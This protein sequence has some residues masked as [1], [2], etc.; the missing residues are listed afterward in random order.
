[1]RLLLRCRPNQDLPSVVLP[2]LDR[3]GRSKEALLGRER[4][5]FCS[6]QRRR[7]RRRQRWQQQQKPITKAGRARLY[8][9]HKLANRHPN[10]SPPDPASSG[11]A[12]P[13][14][15]VLLTRVLFTLLPKPTEIRTATRPARSAPS[16]PGEAKRTA[17]YMCVFGGL[18]GREG[19]RDGGTEEGRME[20]LR[21]RSRARRAAET[22]STSEFRL[23]VFC[24]PGTA[25]RRSRGRAGPAASPP[26]ASSPS[27][28]G[29]A[30][31]STTIAAAPTASSP[32]KRE[33]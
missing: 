21:N 24:H 12:R 15:L 14:P 32:R 10:H 23:L 33:A 18:R 11:P 3:H 28:T 6:K 19:R 5:S 29:R 25:T 20:P 26:S 27:P 7:R 17:C 22:D 4:I 2:R 13:R 16:F 31:R 30:R 9:E 8:F 1:M